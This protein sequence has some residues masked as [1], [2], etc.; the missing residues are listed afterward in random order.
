MFSN[1][2]VRRCAPCDRDWPNLELYNLCGRCLRCTFASTADRLPDRATALKEAARYQA[3]RDFDAEQ[4]AKADI[5]RQTWDEYMNA[6]FGL[7]APADAPTNY[8]L[9]GGTTSPPP[10]NAQDV[11]FHEADDA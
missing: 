3:Y 5:A 8:G 11:R 4:D 6:L 9:A 7:S 2:P 10:T 1:H